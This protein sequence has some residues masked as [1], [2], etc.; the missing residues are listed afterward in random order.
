MEKNK[1]RIENSFSTLLRKTGKTAVYIRTD[2]K[3]KTISTSE[4]QSESLSIGNLR[5]NAMVFYSSDF[6]KE[7]DE[8]NKQILNAVIDNFYQNPCREINLYLFKTPFSVV[9]SKSNPER[10]FIERLCKHEN[11][12][13]FESWIKSRDTGFYQIEYS[14]TSAGGKTFKDPKIQS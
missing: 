11:T 5:H 13:Y 1:I 2:V 12:P 8:E 9:F 6:N 3:P 14:I 7:L 10:R 4:I